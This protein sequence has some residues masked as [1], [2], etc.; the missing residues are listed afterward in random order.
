M[1]AYTNAAIHMTVKPGKTGTIN[2]NSPTSITKSVRVS[3][4]VCK[5]RD[6]V[7]MVFSAIHSE[8]NDRIDST[9]EQKKLKAGKMARNLTCPV[10][11]VQRFHVAQD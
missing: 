11:L 5:R 10:A 6:P 1:S 7:G 3:S 2:P 8:W 4:R 9:W